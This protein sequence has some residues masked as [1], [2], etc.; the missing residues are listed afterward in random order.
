MRMAAFSLAASKLLR[1]V[2]ASTARCLP[3]LVW[4]TVPTHERNA[5]SN[6]SGSSAA[7]TRPNVPR[8]ARPFGS[9]LGIPC[10]RSRNPRNH[11]SFESPNS[12]ISFQPSAPQMTAQIAM[13]RMPGPSGPDVRPALT[14]RVVKL[15]QP[16]ALH[17]R[18]ANKMEAFPDRLAHTGLQPLRISDMGVVGCL[19]APLEVRCVCPDLAVACAC[20]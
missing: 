17:P 19:R 4:A 3:A 1:R 16:C 20:A 15:V 18:I 13:T 7:N 10:G 11:S 12:S 6:P 5:V 8:S 2:L 14:R 9:W